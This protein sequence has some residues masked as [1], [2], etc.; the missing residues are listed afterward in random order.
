LKYRRYNMNEIEK[1]IEHF[2]YGITHDI[3][4]EPVTTYAR[5]AV[6]ALREK[7]EREKGGRAMSNTLLPCPFCGGE[8]EL[9]GVPHIPKGWD[10]IP[11]CKTTSCCGR[12]A[13]KYS[14]RE[15]AI[16]AW[17]RRANLGSCE[18]ELIVRCKNC[19]HYNQIGCS[20]GFGWCERMDIGTN[21]NFYCWLAERSEG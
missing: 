10:F 12:Q 9:Y 7:T 17:N 5:L 16:A 1:A 8:A 14:N 6:D 20:D 13:K 19:K 21:D 18:N 3:F 11:R 4:S 15:T 2:H